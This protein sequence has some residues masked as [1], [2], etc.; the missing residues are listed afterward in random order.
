MLYA[1]SFLFASRI[2]I[3]KMIAKRG[4]NALQTKVEVIPRFWKAYPALENPTMPPTQIA[5]CNK[6]IPI[7]RDSCG[8]TSVTSADPTLLLTGMKAL[9]AAKT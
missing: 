3:N 6:D 2:G 1:F 8:T 7:P 9:K 4:R 5:A